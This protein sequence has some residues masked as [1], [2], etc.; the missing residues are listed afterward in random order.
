MEQQQKQAN[1]IMRLYLFLR[2]RDAKIVELFFLALNL[3]ILA[4]IVLPPYGYYGWALIAR[5]IFQLI[6]TG[7]NLIAISKPHKTIRVLSSTANSAVMGLVSSSLWRMDSPHTGT[8]A[9]LALLAAF[10]CWKITIRQ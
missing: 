10:V 6:V 1:V 5:I 7:L 8:Y 2:D 9:L 4:L 3:Y